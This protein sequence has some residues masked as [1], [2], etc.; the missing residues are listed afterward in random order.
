[1]PHFQDGSKYSPN[2]AGAREVD[3]GVFV[4]PIFPGNGFAFDIAYGRISGTHASVRNNVS[5]RAYIVTNGN[6][7]ISVGSRS[8]DVAAGDVVTVPKGAVHSLTGEADYII[9]TAPPFSPENEEVVAG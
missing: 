1:M 3:P 9:V 6:A 2:P 5:Q 4:D 8:H 7:V